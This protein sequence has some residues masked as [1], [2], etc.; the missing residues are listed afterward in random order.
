MLKILSMVTRWTGLAIDLRR[1]TDNRLQKKEQQKAENAEGATGGKK[2][3]VTAA[4]LRV[5]KGMSA[6]S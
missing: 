1:K 2:K 3:K 4:Q 5:Q 6:R